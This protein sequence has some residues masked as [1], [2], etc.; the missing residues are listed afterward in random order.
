MD[1]ESVYRLLKTLSFKG[2]RSFGSEFRFFL[3]VS[4]VGVSV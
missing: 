3:E 2:S 1:P 4:H